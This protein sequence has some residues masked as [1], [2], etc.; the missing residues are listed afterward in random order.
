MKKGIQQTKNAPMRKPRLRAAR[1][2]RVSLSL[3]SPWSALPLPLAVRATTEP[4]DSPE[5]SPGTDTWFSDK[6]RPLSTEYVTK[7][8]VL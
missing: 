6:S 3:V 4:R 5:D 1:V 2:S 8:N 7:H